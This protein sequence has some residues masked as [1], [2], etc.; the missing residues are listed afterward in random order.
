MLRCAGQELT[1][2][3]GLWQA[4]HECVQEMLTERL[5]PAHRVGADMKQCECP[6]ACAFRRFIVR[7]SETPSDNGDMGMTEAEFL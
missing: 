5:T 3:N 2:F 7:S 6:P 4:V 1:R